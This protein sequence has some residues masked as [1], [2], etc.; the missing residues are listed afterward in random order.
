MVLVLGAGGSIAVAAASLLWI[1]QKE[2]A[3]PTSW[4]YE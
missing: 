4:W 3:V 1:V 2:Y